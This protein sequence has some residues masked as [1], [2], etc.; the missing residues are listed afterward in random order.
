M[1]IMGLM[2]IAGLTLVVIGLTG[3]LLVGLEEGEEE[4]TA[5]AEDPSDPFGEIPNDQT[6]TERG[7]EDI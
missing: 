3:L 7:G 2:V 5:E 4:P 6:Q 1:T